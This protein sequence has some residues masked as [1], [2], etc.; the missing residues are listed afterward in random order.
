MRLHKKRFYKKVIKKVTV[1]ALIFLYLTPWNLAYALVET[2]HTL[3][4]DTSFNTEGYSD[5]TSNVTVSN[6]EVRLNIKEDWWNEDYQYKRGLTV[7]NIGTTASLSAGTPIQATID[8]SSLGLGTTKLQTDLDDLRV[9][10]SVGSTHTEIARSYFLDVGNTAVATLTF[11]LQTELGI[12]ATNTNYSIY[13]GNTEATYSLGSGYDFERD[14]DDAQAT[15]VCPF[16]GTTTCVDGE[17]PST[18]TGAMSLMGKMI[19]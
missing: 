19:M 9:V 13:Y 8:L 2:T 16:N 10:Y 3:P 5:D 15:L 17:T 6:T 14:G 4:T 7:R 1:V 11:P 12:G 18:E